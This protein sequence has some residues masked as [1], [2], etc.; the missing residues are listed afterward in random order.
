[1]QLAN[2]I[3]DRQIVR[4]L[5]GDFASFAM[6]AVSALAG[7]VLTA[8]H[9]DDPVVWTAV[10]VVLAVT[11]VRFATTWR[12]LARP[13]MEARATAA[14]KTVYLVS[15]AAHVFALGCWAFTLFVF[16]DDLFSQMMAFA[17][18]VG[19]LVGVQGRNFASSLIV[20]LQL[21]AAALPV[22]A[23]LL[24]VG[25][26]WYAA[27]ALFYSLFI[28]SILRTSGR[29][30]DMFADV[31]GSAVAS[32]RAARTDNLT[33]LANRTAIEATIDSATVLNETTFALHFIDLDRFKHINDSLGHAAG[34][35][36]L[37]VVA[38]RFV[39]IAGQSGTVARFAGDEFIVLQRE[40]S[41]S[42]AVDLAQKLQ[43][44]LI[45]PI[46]VNG[47]EIVT[48]CSIGTALFPRD[49]RTG[50]R[51]IQRADTALFRAKRDGRAT[52]RMFSPE[53]AEMELQRMQIEADLRTALENGGLTLAFQPIIDPQTRRI[54][55]CEA[56]ARW[57]VPGGGEITPGRF[58]PIADEAGLMNALT[59]YTLTLACKTAT[60]W[61]DA[62]SIAVNLSPKQLYR[63]DLVQTVRTICEV[64]GLDPKRLELEITENN[65]MIDLDMMVDRLKALKAMGIRLSIDD[66]G[67]GYSNLG[68]MA[69]LPVD[70]V[71]ID[72][73]F[74]IGIEADASKRALLR[75]AIHFIASL[76]MGVI[77]EGVETLGQL[78]ILQDEPA[79]TAIQG[80][81]YGTPLPAPEI[82]E[83]IASMQPSNASLLQFPLSRR[84]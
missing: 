53:M 10:C 16:T 71:K 43:R 57:H 47:L 45:E 79:I 28:L 29:M 38:A 32:E 40:A 46:A 78:E 5:F 31:V 68:R 25:S 7:A 36:L 18:C 72:R 19:Y 52:H 2:R 54:V 39:H 50:E 59:D 6:G 3:D 42:S 75:G 70:T 9:S 80:F 34:D 63:A 13:P 73:A 8:V 23:G 62:M 35:A 64:T 12:F 77:V 48:K 69:S 74:V 55:S 81:I 27:L 37:K 49:G 33:G 30:H 83:F 44:A 66:F 67:T 20:K 14:W 24:A 26:P 17:I 21:A 51:L 41:A 1:M 76:G 61:P 60:T 11:L 84:S 58:L 65:A 15:G 22:V 56:L 82:L 4:S